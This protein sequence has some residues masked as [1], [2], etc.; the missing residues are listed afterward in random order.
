MELL[1]NSGAEIDPKDRFKVH[2]I[3]TL[4]ICLSAEATQLHIQQY[5]FSHS[6]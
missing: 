2:I 4:Y 1:I 6:L 3:M 5:S